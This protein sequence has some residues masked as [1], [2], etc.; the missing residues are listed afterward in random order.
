[1]ASTSVAAHILQPSDILLHQ[2]PRIC[3]DCHLGELGCDGGDGPRGQSAD[4]GEFVNR[5]FGH[6]AG[7]CG[8]AQR[9]EGLQRFLFT[10]FV[11]L[12]FRWFMGI[13]SFGLP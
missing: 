13:G 12:V 9:I 3:F 4:F 7:R 11:S 8:R 1:M 2:S 6:D 10:C 5:V